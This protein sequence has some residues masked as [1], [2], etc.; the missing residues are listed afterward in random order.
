MF[1]FTKKQGYH[2]FLGEIRRVSD[3]SVDLLANGNFSHKLFEILGIVLR[4]A[5]ILLIAKAPDKMD[6]LG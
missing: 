1:N 3:Q 4:A 2:L 6:F 5:L